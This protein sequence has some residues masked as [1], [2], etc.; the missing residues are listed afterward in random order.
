M[1]LPINFYLG[2]FINRKNNINKIVEALLKD[3]QS[4][5]YNICEC[6]KE[7]NCESFIIE[8]FHNLGIDN[9]V[10]EESTVFIRILDNIY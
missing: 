8:K 10:I 2:K 6:L 1:S 7:C 9:L 3:E 5:E 4:C